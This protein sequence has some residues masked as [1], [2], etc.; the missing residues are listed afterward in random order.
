MGRVL[1][2]VVLVAVVVAGALTVVHLAKSTPQKV[3][4]IFAQD[5]DSGQYVKTCTLSQYMRTCI[6]DHLYHGTGLRFENL[7]VGQVVTDGDRAIALINGKV[8]ESTG[9]CL[10]FTKSTLPSG[11]SFT[12]G[13]GPGNPDIEHNHILLLSDGEIGQ[14]LVHGHHRIGGPHHHHPGAAADGL[15]PGNEPRTSRVGGP[16]RPAM[17]PLGGPPG[18]SWVCRGAPGAARTT[19]GSAQMVPASYTDYFIAAAGAAGVLI[20][21]LFVAVSLRSESVFGPGARARG[22]PWPPAVSAPW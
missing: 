5:L 7:T 3:A 4:A 18:P 15:E 21:L 12:R 20:G 19:V 2:V 14:S 17:A 6:T 22:G 13:L 1:L 11:W 8:C 16:R 10:T 9:S